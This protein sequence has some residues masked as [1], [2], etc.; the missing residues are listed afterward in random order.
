MSYSSL[1]KT[2]LVE[3][4]FLWL[5]CHS[6]RDWNKNQSCAVFAK[7]SENTTLIFIPHFE[8]S[9]AVALKRYKNMGIRFLEL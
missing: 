6:L 9:Q 5:K 4:Y 3:N 2:S 1:S 8:G 7:H